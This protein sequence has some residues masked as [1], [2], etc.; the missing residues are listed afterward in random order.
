MMIA[1]PTTGAFSLIRCGSGADSYGIDMKWVR[2]IYGADRM[3]RRSGSNSQ[4]GV[5]GD[6]TGEVPVFSLAEKIRRPEN[7]TATTRHIVVFPGGRGHWGLLVDRVSRAIRATNPVVPLAP[8]LTGP[9]PLFAGVLLLDDDLLLMLAPDQMSPRDGAGA[10]DAAGVER[11]PEWLPPPA[12]GDAVPD[13]P[14]TPGNG[15]LVLFFAT[16]AAVSERPLAFGVSLAQ[17][18]E[19]LEVPPLLSVPLAPPHVLGLAKWRSQPVPVLDL[20][21]TLGLPPSVRDERSRLIVMRVPQSKAKIGFLVRPT[22][23]LLPL[24]TPHWPCQRNLAIPQA[25]LIGAVDLPDVT[26]VVPN[27]VNIW[28]AVE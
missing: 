18:L 25:L 23:K 17:V 16:D 13:V 28:H 7:A 1:P 10:A 22:V 24:P 27:L 19:V 2:G 4:I 6:A 5:L 26:V 8:A 3:R 20:G 9:T 14:T 12:N 11:S 21:M 15:R